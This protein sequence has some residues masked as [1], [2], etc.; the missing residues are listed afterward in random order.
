MQRWKSKGSLTV[1]AMLVTPLLLAMLILLIG[2]LLLPLWQASNFS[3]A[4]MQACRQMSL[5]DKQEVYE[6]GERKTIVAGEGEFVGEWSTDV[7]GVLKTLQYFT[8]SEL[9]VIGCRVG[10]VQIMR[11]YSNTQTAMLYSSY[12]SGR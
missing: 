4:C 11:M 2:Y 5:C 12:C 7:P 3:S 9:P 1:E 6:N 10:S 8:E